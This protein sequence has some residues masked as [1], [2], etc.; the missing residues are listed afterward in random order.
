MGAWRGEP[1][2]VLRVRR[3]GLPESGP[4]V[5]RHLGVPRERLALHV[6]RA[7]RLVPEHLE[8]RT[9]YSSTQPGLE[10]VGMGHPGSGGGDGDREG[11][12]ETLG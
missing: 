1:D 2:P 5:H 7:C 4:P 12:M 8:T 6:L 9:L 11:V 3:F 10:Q